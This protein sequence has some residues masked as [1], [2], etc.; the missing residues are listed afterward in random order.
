MDPKVYPRL[1]HLFPETI[2]RIYPVCSSSPALAPC[3]RPGTHIYGSHSPAPQHG[4]PHTHRRSWASKPA[5]RGRWGN[6][7]GHSPPRDPSSQHTTW[8][9]GPEREGGLLVGDKCQMQTGMGLLQPMYCPQGPS[10]SQ[11]CRG[12]ALG[13]PLWFLEPEQWTAGTQSLPTSL[14]WLPCSPLP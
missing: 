4:G 8:G 6:K 14:P 1:F 7:E 13:G 5:A 10:E 12:S 11:D 2:R 9:K 3:W